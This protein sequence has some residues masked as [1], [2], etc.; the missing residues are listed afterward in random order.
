MLVYNKK[1]TKEEVELF[2]QLSYKLWNSVS[3]DESFTA[4]KT[5]F[6]QIF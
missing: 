2:D 6:M 4:I 1:V 5:I 3:L